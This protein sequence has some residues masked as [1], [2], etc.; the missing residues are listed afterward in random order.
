MV[1]SVN[2]DQ[3]N[4]MKEQEGLAKARQNL[5][6]ERAEA[7]REIASIQQ[8]TYELAREIDRHHKNLIISQAATW[9]SVKRAGE[10]EK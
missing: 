7:E 5:T 6:E 10:T 1:K 8:R 3:K 9:K 4:I 2:K